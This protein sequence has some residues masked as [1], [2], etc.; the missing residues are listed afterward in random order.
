MSR[1]NPFMPGLKFG[2]WVT[3]C[4]TTC[5]KAIY[6]CECGT[7]KELWTSNVRNG[8]SRSCGCLCS[9]VNATAKTTHGLSRTPAYSVWSGMIQ[10]CTNPKRNRYENYAGRGIAVCERWALF[11]NFVADMGQP[12]EGM[13]LER[14]ENDKGYFRENCEW[15]PMSKQANNK[16]TSHKLTYGG[17]TQTVAEWA[18]ELSVS[19]YTLHTRIKL[20]WPV[21]KVLTEPLRYGGRP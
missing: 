19:P 21:D 15:A 18:R 17:K 6:E 7:I 12:P 14:K 11:E 4:E 10:R 9:E 3:V 13:T 16:S 8:K 1:Q 20:N 2:R 5:G